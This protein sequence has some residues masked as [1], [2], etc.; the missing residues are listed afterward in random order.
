MATFFFLE[1]PVF[2]LGKLEER[3]RGTGTDQIYREREERVPDFVDR[4]GS[5]FEI[6][7]GSQSTGERAIF[8]DPGPGSHVPGS[9]S[10]AFFSVDRTGT[11]S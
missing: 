9:Q 4:T 7:Q 6:F 3:E 8:C 1:K 10:I 11:R 2:W 5:L